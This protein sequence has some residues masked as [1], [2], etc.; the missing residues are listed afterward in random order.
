MNLLVQAFGIVITA[1]Q[2]AMAMGGS[3]HGKRDRLLIL[4][5]GVN[6]QSGEK[7]NFVLSLPLKSFET[8]LHINERPHGLVE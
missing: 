2:L 8:F 7:V 5:A 4:E 6:T 1:C 3:W